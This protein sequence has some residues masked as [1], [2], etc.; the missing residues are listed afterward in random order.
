MD[1]IKGWECLRTTQFKS[2]FFKSLVQSESFNFL[3]EPTLKFTLTVPLFFC[4]AMRVNRGLAMA[5]RCGMEVLVVKYHPKKL[6]YPFH[7]ELNQISWVKGM[8]VHVTWIKHSL[9]LKC[10]VYADRGLK[11]L[12]KNRP[13][14]CVFCITVEGLSIG[15]DTFPHPMQA[16]SLKTERCTVF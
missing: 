9:H 2:I 12:I 3:Y 11:Q 6:H 16:S 4:P 8:D 15:A 13:T 10:I 5:E 1:S 7:S 14:I